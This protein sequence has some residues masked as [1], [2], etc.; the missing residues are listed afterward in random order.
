MISIVESLIRRMRWK[1]FFFDK[2]NQ[3]EEVSFNSY[4]FNSER[5]PPQSNALIPFENDLYNML[6]SITFTNR[7]SDFQKQLSRVI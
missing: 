7:R 5:A 4:G 2:D 1:A 6:S 3:S